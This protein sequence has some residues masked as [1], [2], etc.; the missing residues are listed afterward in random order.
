MNRSVL[1]CS[2]EREFSSYILES[3]FKVGKYKGPRCTAIAISQ[4]ST[5]ISNLERRIFCSER[6]SERELM[7]AKRCFQC[8]SSCV[9]ILNSVVYTEN[10]SFSAIKN[11]I[12]RAQ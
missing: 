10:L 8:H 7:R 11:K 12:C 1:E 6:E 3:F 4:I 9:K 5:K 2:L